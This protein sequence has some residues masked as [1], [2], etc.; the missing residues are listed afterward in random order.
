VRLRASA[1]DDD[2]LIW[3]GRRGSCDGTDAQ[4]RTSL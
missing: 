1:R 4:R 2:P 3:P